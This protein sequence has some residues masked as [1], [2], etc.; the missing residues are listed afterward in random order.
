MYWDNPNPQIMEII[1]NLYSPYTLGWTNELLVEIGKDF[2][3]P[4]I[5][6]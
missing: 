5:P 4:E 6:G 1:S 2:A 3:F